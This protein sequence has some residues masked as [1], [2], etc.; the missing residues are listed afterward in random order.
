LL[1][2]DGM[3]QRCQHRKS[4]HSHFAVLCKLTDLNPPGNLRLEVVQLA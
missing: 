1:S 2:S 3:S 4:R